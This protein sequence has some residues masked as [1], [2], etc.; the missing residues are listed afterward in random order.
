VAGR[1]GPSA[2]DLPHLVV[3]APQLAINCG[4]SARLLGPAW[5]LRQIRTAQVEP[6]GAEDRPPVHR[7]TGLDRRIEVILGE[8]RTTVRGSSACPAGIGTAHARHGCRIA[9]APILT[10]ERCRLSP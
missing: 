2:A 3:D 4:R 1:V 8:H 10:H 9:H 7:L 6:G 5:E